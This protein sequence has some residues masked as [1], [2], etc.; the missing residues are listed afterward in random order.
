M[1]RKS[2]SCFSV[3][4]VLFFFF[5]VE[6]FLSLNV[7]FAFFFLFKNHN[8]G[9]S[10]EVEEGRRGRVFLPH[11]E[12]L[13]FFYWV[14]LHRDPS[15][16]PHPI[17]S[18]KHCCKRSSE[19]LMPT[20]HIPCCVIIAGHKKL[21]PMMMELHNKKRVKHRPP[22]QQIIDDIGHSTCTCEKRKRE[23]E[24]CRRD[25]FKAPRH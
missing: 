7:L 17:P 12:V 25:R 19:A 6:K 10:G 1:K 11:S 2:P 8:S 22:Q 23:C 5:V 9:R 24:N 13:G 4:F 16:S 14:E 3:L 18:N 21:Q 15:Q 20:L